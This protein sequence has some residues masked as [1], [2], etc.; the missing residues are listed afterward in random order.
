MGGIAVRP[1]GQHRGCAC[2]GGFAKATHMYPIWLFSRNDA[3]ANVGVIMLLPWSPD[4]ASLADLLVAA[5]I[6]RSSLFDTSL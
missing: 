6:A 5:V 2:A 4:R 3:I 1:D